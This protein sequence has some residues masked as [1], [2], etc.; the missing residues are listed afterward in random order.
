MEIRLTNQEAENIFH[1]ALCNGLSQLG[2]Y[3]LEL[4]YSDKHYEEAKSIIKK[5]KPNEMICY[6]DV[7]MKILKMGYQLTLKD[8]EGG[9]DDVVFKIIDVYTG[10]KR[11][12]HKQIIQM[13][14]E[15]DDAYTA[16]IILQ[17]VILG[18]HVYG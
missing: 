5:D 15:E 2:N 14:D 4:V 12:P 10:M 6:E 13:V 3:G 8:N 11:V 9:E 1:T 18:D 16:D 7:L 17:Y